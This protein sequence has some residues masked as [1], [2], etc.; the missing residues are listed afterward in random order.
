MSPRILH[1]CSLALCT[2]NNPA[3]PNRHQKAQE[4]V[5]RFLSAP[6]AEKS[7]ILILT[8]A[9]LARSPPSIGPVKSA[10]GTFLR[11]VH[12]DAPEGEKNAAARGRVAGSFSRRRGAETAVEEVHLGGG[13][14]TVDL[15][16]FSF[17]SAAMGGI[18]SR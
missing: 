15:A 6:S 17:D 2:A 10:Q 11:V 7:S 3:A 8:N 14:D 16:P 13:G 12:F 5:K 18:R 1:N 9:A 4:H